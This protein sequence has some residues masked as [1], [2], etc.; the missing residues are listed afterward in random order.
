M[1]ENVHGFSNSICSLDK[2]IKA[3]LNYSASLEISMNI[4]GSEDD[5]IEKYLEK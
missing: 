5:G 2:L 1:H 3:C 4:P